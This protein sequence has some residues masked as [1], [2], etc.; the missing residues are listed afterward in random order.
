[1]TTHPYKRRLVLRAGVQ[2]AF[3]QVAIQTFTVRGLPRFGPPA[4]GPAQADALL[5]VPRVGVERDRA[6]A[7]ERFQAHDG[8]HEFHAVVSGAPEAAGDFLA[9]PALEEDGGI[10]T[11][12]GVAQTGP[13]GVDGDGLRFRWHGASLDRKDESSFHHKRIAESILD[14]RAANLARCWELRKLFVRVP[15]AR[16]KTGTATRKKTIGCKEQLSDCAIFKAD[17]RPKK[18]RSCNQRTFR[19]HDSDVIRTMPAKA[20]R[21]AVVPPRSNR[22]N[23]PAYDKEKYKGRHRV[24]RLF[25]RLQHFRAVATRSDQLAP[26][27]LGGILAA[28]LAVKLT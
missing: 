1:M 6:A 11:G 7:G 4:F 10:P 8:R 5:D 27:F 25:D 3:P 14:F 23:P 21:E 9:V 2:Q 13:V 28:L 15:S 18:R 20:N 24:E 16:M 26:M 12:T 17:T 22:L 19:A